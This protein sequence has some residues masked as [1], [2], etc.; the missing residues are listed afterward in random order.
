LTLNLEAEEENN[1]RRAHSLAWLSAGDIAV[2][3]R[4]KHC[5]N[6]PHV[7]E[8]KCAWNL[9]LARQKIAHSKVEEIRNRLIASM[10]NQKYLGQADGGF[11]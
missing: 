9:A 2:T 11:G 4:G 10:A 7:V 3:A 1:F 5:E 8:A 6:Q